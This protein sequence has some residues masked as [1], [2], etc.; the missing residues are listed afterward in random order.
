M[1]SRHDL[2]PEEISLILQEHV[3]RL[4]ALEIV[5]LQFWLSVDLVRRC[6]DCVLGLTLFWLRAVLQGRR[7]VGCDVVQVETSDDRQ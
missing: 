5:F 3:A 7:R 1:M 6:V 4:S 2:S